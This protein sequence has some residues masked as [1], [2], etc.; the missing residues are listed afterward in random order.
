M[1]R[2][3]AKLRFFAGRLRRWAPRTLHTC[4]MCGAEVLYTQR[5]MHMWRAHGRA[6]PIEDMERHFGGKRRGW[7]RRE[8]RTRNA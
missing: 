7:R 5:G 8:R 1:T 6:I 2:L 4:S 3:G